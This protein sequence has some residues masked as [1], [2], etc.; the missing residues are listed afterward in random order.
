VGIGSLVPTSTF[1][2]RCGRRNS[3]PHHKPAPPYPLDALPLSGFRQ[4][5]T[6]HISYKSGTFCR[7]PLVGRV[8]TPVTERSRLLLDSVTITLAELA[9]RGRRPGGAARV[10]LTPEL[11]RRFLSSR[12]P[13]WYKPVQRERVDGYAALIRAWRFRH[14]LPAFAGN[15][16]DDRVQAWRGSLRSGTPRAA[17]VIA[18]SW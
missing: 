2:S 11:V 6:A 1:E 17:P 3:A 13:G 8:N 9:D 12:E 16:D 7:N 18:S 14:G 15:F 4:N 10:V 5:F